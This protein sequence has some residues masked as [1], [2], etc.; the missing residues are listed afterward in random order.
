V[1]AEEEHLSRRHGLVVHQAF[2]LIPPD[3]ALVGLCPESSLP[4][5]PL[6]G[7]YTRKCRGLVTL[8]G[9]AGREYPYGR[10]REKGLRWN[11]RCSGRPVPL[12]VPAV[13]E[14]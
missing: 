11:G 10:R 7:P 2:G 1:P 4:N 3:R 8:A 9:D 5:S 6:R 13:I 12:P 14:R